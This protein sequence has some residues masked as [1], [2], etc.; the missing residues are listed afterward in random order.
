MA[1]MTTYSQH[2]NF[3]REYIERYR[4][5]IMA[6]YP[7]KTHKAKFEIVVSQLV[8]LF[9]ETARKANVEVNMLFDILP[10]LC[11]H[12]LKTV[13]LDGVPVKFDELLDDFIVNHPA[14]RLLELG[15]LD[16]KPGKSQIGP[17]EF[18][19]CLL[20]GS[21]VFSI[22]PK[23]GYDNI[24]QVKQSEF[25]LD[26]NGIINTDEKLQHYVD[27]PRVEQFVVVSLRSASKKPRL[28]YTK[29]SW[30]AAATNPRDVAEIRGGK[31]M[32]LNM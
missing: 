2:F 15:L 22:N 6:A 29:H 1:H 9:Y 11:S 26:N 20:D 12:K 4:P 32:F 5:G 17:M 25:K 31:L 14:W 23:L 10:E 16:F 7:T 13:P 30:I 8:C 28:E 21:N 19:V 27:D 18:A 3:F 24:F